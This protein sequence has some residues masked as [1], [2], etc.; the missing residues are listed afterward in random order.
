MVY[1][2]YLDLSGMD[3]VPFISL[4]DE[5]KSVN[6]LSFP[7]K[8]Q[9]DLRMNMWIHS[10]SNAF[11]L[12]MMKCS[13]ALSCWLFGYAPLKTIRIKLVDKFGRGTRNS[14]YSAGMKASLFAKI[15]A[16]KFFPEDEIV[17]EN[18]WSKAKGMC[19]RT[20]SVCLSGKYEE[21]PYYFDEK[22][23]WR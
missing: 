19:E 18:C 7:I 4:M 16:E 13:T 21:E 23:I 11:Y 22:A 2:D 15:I 8:G 1:D 12:Y 17:W 14:Y 5:T 20:M 3:L 6:R 10:D 9:D